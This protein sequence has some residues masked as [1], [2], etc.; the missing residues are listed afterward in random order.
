MSTPSQKISQ[1][2]QKSKPN[3]Q[4]K[5]VKVNTPRNSLYVTPFGHH[6]SQYTQTL[7]KNAF[8]HYKNH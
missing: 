3:I 8:I 7:D 6:M 4:V 1:I 2:S 5:I